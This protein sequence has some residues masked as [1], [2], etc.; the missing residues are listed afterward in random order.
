MHSCDVCIHTVDKKY[1]Q[2]PKLSEQEFS[3]LNIGSHKL[4]SNPNALNDTVWDS[5]EIVYW[6][7]DSQYEFLSLSQQTSLIKSAFLETSLLTPLKIREK[8]KQTGD[9][10]I[11]IN[12][13]GAKDEKFFKDRGSVLA[14]AYGPQ[15]GVGGDVTM[16]SDHVWRL[17]KTPI[18]VKDAFDSGLIEDYDKNHPDNIL[19]TFDPIHTMKH[20]AG[21]HSCGMR[22]LE[23]ENL[24]G[25]AIMYPFYNG[26]R[27][28][29][30]EDRNYL[31]E[32]YGK[33]NV[34]SRVS[35]FMQHYMGRF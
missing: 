10:H 21:G 16:N 30:K 9:A 11:K 25:S 15:D 29:S 1:T 32:L 13:L 19:K 17:D 4:I 14:F 22:H 35:K 27:V 8:R 7:L 26:N 18:S 28:F 12:W 31:F 20:E 3:A 34:A 23:D 33:S 5:S 6:Q 2:T 24:K